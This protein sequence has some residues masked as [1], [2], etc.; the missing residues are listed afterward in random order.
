MSQYERNHD[1]AALGASHHIVGDEQRTVYPY[2][3]QGG[4]TL[5]DRQEMLRRQNMIHTTYL[6][7]GVAVAGCMAGAWWGSHSMGFLEAIFNLGK[8]GFLGLFIMLNVLPSLAISVAE[9]NPRMAVPALGG[10]GIFS[11]LVISPL[12]ALAM[13]LSGQGVQ[14]GG[15]LVSTALVIT[16]AMFAAV[17]AYIF[18]NKTEI[19]VSKAISWGILGFFVAAFPL[20]YFFQ[21]PMWI[22]L[23]AGV[24]ALIGVYQIAVGTS[25]LATDARFKSPAAGA[26]LLFAGVFNVFTSV[27]RILIASRR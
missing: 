14:E 26:L 15:D 2:T 1:G 13:I 9:K 6:Y 5:P 11:G 27:L 4:A 23:F 18:M 21:S 19:R 8:I 24:T 3:V 7:L 12:V 20:S 16:G 17:T 22:L 10:F 25:A